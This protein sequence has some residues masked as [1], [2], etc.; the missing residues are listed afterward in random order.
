MQTHGYPSIRY[1]YWGKSKI[2][3]WTSNDSLVDPQQ[4]YLMATY[5]FSEIVKKIEIYHQRPDNYGNRITLID[6]RHLV[7]SVKEKRVRHLGRCYTFLP[8]PN[9]LKL[10]V[11][12]ITAQL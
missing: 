5:N 10:G 9:I 1:Y 3:H 12:Y 4:L 11:N 2:I 6:L 7:H 8:K